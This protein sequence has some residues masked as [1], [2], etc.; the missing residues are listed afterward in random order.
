MAVLTIQTA[1]FDPQ[2]DE[3][4]IH[5]CGV[6]ASTSLVPVATSHRSCRHYPLLHGGIQ[7]KTRK[8][9]AAKCSLLKQK[10]V[11]ISRKIIVKGDK[12]TD[13]RKEF[14]GISVYAVI[15]VADGLTINAACRSAQCYSLRELPL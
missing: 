12:Q 10:V 9:L 1:L 11:F 7:L 6:T 13:M 15:Y 14:L 8:D 3:Y 2:K 4:L 5:F